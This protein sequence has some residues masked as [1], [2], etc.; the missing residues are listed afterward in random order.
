MTKKQKHHETL[1]IVGPMKFP[2]KA[3]IP[4]LKAKDAGLI[5]VDGGLV[6]EK[7]FKKKA[8]HLLADSFSAGDGD[9]S[10][11]KMTMKKTSQDLSDLAWLLSHLTG[12]MKPKRCLLVG[13][14]GGR[15]DH[16]L[17][18]LG[19]VAQYLARFKKHCAPL[20]QLDDKIIFTGAGSHTATIHGIFSLASFEKNKIKIKGQCE[21]QSKNWLTMAPLSSRGVSNVGYGEFTVETQKPLAIIRA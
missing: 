6:H 13:F 5:F 10:R 3:V 20:I 1:I 18:N 11:K 21:Y 9:S 2:W 14:S 8:P 4:F 7:N 17:F 19:E 16:M 12:M 15:M